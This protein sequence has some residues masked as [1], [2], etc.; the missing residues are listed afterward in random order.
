MSPRDTGFAKLFGSGQNQKLLAGLPR[1][2]REQ[3]IGS[4]L[5]SHQMYAAASDSLD[6]ADWLATTFIKLAAGGEWILPQTL[7]AR[8][9]GHMAAYVLYTI[10]YLDTLGAL[11]AY[12]ESSPFNTT[13][14]DGWR[15]CAK[16]ENFSTTGSRV[17]IVT[18]QNIDAITGPLRLRF[19]ASAAAQ[20]TVRAELI[21]KQPVAHH[22]VLWLDDMY[23][24][25]TGQ[26]TTYL[27]A[28]AWLD[29]SRFLHVFALLE[30]S[31]DPTQP[32]LLTVKLE[33]AASMSADPNAWLQVASSA[34]I[35]GV[36]VVLDGRSSVT[37]P[38]MSLLRLA[39]T[40]SA[41]VS[42]TLRVG[43]LMKGN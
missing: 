5:D 35:P 22:S 34:M 30:W 31:G 4:G 8:A 11:S 2:L 14:S 41:A 17:F 7:Y 10:D 6:N 26:D 37:N 32:N 24:S 33:T 27:Q 40:A 15:Q 43:L 23:V 38:P 20:F 9:E 16:F 12:L 3:L 28:D 42:G 25:F 1:S 29:V 36:A 39:F 19:T 13:D 18:P 21:L